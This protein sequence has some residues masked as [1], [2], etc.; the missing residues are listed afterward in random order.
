MVLS[1]YQTPS[2]LK[3]HEYLR[4][5]SYQFISE[6]VLFKLVHALFAFLNAFSKSSS[7]GS[8]HR[9]ASCDLP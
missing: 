4:R 3:F 8:D 9:E 7:R 5:N 2:L 6:C 1:V